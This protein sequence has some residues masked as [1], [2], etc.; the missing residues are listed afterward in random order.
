MHD[1]AAQ[2]K[3]LEVWVKEREVLEFTCLLADTKDDA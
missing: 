2:H 1:I 3:E